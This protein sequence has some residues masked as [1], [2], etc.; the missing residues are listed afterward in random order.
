[1]K[2]IELENERLLNEVETMT[3]FFGLPTE[4]Y[5]TKEEKEYKEFISRNLN[6]V[7]KTPSE[8]MNCLNSH[9][10]NME[11][12]E[13]E[14]YITDYFL[15]CVEKYPTYIYTN[16]YTKQG[17]LNI[18][19]GVRGEINKA[20]ELNNKN[21]YRLYLNPSTHKPTRLQI[22]DVNHFTDII[23]SYDYSTSKWALR[24]PDDYYTFYKNNK[25][26]I[27]IIKKQFQS[28]I[29]T[30]ATAAHLNYVNKITSE[31]PDSTKFSECKHHHMEKHA[32]VLPKQEYTK[33]CPYIDNEWIIAGYDTTHLKTF[34]TDIPKIRNLL[35]ETRTLHRFM[36]IFKNDI[37][38]EKYG[39]GK[40]IDNN[41]KKIIPFEKGKPIIDHTKIVGIEPIFDIDI[42][43]EIKK[44]DAFFDPEIFKQYQKTINLFSKK[45]NE[46]DD[47]LEG[48][49]SG[50][51]L[52]LKLKPFKFD[53]E[54]TDFKE[55]DI[56][57]ENI[58]QEMQ[59]EMTENNINK[60]Q[61]EKG[62]GW[63]RYFKVAGTFHAKSERISIPLN[64][65]EEL[66]S[67]WI[68]EMTKI[69]KG[70]TQNVSNEIINRSEWK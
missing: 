63:S 2:E 34:P 25:E 22:M 11:R 10:K 60:L 23:K 3:A 66:D 12:H 33:M 41:G 5:N 61:I 59:K 35:L 39:I 14:K 42:K 20:I 65:N 8:Y 15:K 69:E 43:N 21:I 18:S 6:D 47:S 37:E 30:R 40:V 46:E 28:D 45:Y 70:L 57:W 9:T 7:I 16:T 13:R 36:Y 32:I 52:Y 64:I 38:I 31:K 68:N 55:F 19:K 17:N 56:I 27:N 58:R 4:L 26:F 24:T 67:N 62:Y 51:G 54:D 49:F 48:I 44:I 50:N 53:D 1:M 29:G